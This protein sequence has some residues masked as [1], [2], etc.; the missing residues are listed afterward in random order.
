MLFYYLCDLIVYEQF[1][2]NDLLSDCLSDSELLQQW[3][4][5]WEWLY[6]WSI[7]NKITKYYLLSFA[8]VWQIKKYLKWI[9]SDINTILYLLWLLIFQILRLAGSV[10]HNGSGIKLL[11]TAAYC[12]FW[13]KRR[14]WIYIM[15]KWILFDKNV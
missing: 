4:K 12:Q 5:N 7:S 14:I 8:A 11:V 2:R 10:W 1:F 9:L 13:V 6:N 3:R 15:Q